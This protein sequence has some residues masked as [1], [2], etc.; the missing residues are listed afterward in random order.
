MKPSYIIA[1]LIKKIQLS[2]VKTS[3]I[4]S[5][6]KVAS[7]SHLVNV[8]MDKYSYIGSDCTILNT[9]IGKFCSIADNV[10]VGGASHP[11][12]WVSM[13]PVFHKGRNILKKNF[14]Q[15]TYITSKNTI[16]GNDVWIGNNVLIKAGVNIS[17]GAVIGMGSIVTK[18]IGP[19]EIH[20]GNPAK[21]VRK[22]FDEKTIN[23]LLESEWWNWNDNQIKEKAHIFNDITKFLS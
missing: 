4:H 12:H 22:R 1:K 6:A 18:D 15:N 19:Y 3:K 2:A 7:K 21:M 11:M 8:T 5:T 20:A 14:S 10:I 17:D 23:L 13:S 16:I 9:S